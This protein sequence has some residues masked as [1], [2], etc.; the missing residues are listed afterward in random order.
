MGGSAYRVRLLHSLA[1]RLGI[2][3]SAIRIN[4]LPDGVVTRLLLKTQAEQAIV[5]REVTDAL[6]SVTGDCV[7]STMHVDPLADKLHVRTVVMQAL[8]S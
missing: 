7:A 1:E 8:R 2:V 4:V 3:D 6:K 5:A